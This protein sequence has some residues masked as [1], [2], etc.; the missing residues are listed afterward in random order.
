LQIGLGIGWGTEIKVRYVPKV[1]TDSFKAGTWGVAVQHDISQ[2]IFGEKTLLHLSALGGFTKS[3]GTW[4]FNSEDNQWDGEDQH[5][6]FSAQNFTLQLLASTNIPIVNIYGGLGYNWSKSS[7]DMLG[8]YIIDDGGVNPP[9]E[10][11]NPASAEWKTSG[12]TATVGVRISIAFFKIFADYS[13]KEYNTASVG[14]ALS[15]R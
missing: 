1:G 8:T 3:N 11:T 9:Q 7:F 4:T 13:F 10:L 14:V 6:D 15:F 12:F 5:T 2:Y